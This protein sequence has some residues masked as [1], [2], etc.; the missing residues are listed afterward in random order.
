M[1]YNEKPALRRVLGGCVDYTDYLIIKFFVL[2]VAAFF[3]GVWKGV[4]GR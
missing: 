3:Y 4:T 2:V 1:S